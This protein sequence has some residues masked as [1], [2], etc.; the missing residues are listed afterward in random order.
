MANYASLGTT[1]SSSVYSLL[2]RIN[3][4]SEIVWHMPYDF[5]V[6]DRA[7]R[8]MGLV[9]LPFNLPSREFMHLLDE[10]LSEVSFEMDVF[11]SHQSDEENPGLRDYLVQKFESVESACDRIYMVVLELDPV[12]RDEALNE[13]AEAHDFQS[14]SLESLVPCEDRVYYL[15]WMM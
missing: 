9:I 8:E 3:H 15:W 6:L 1:Y 13:L 7:Q 12:R 4:L 11:L 2:A 14:I 10:D 5:P